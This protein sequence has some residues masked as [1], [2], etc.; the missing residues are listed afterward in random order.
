MFGFKK[1]K[2]RRWRSQPLP[3]AWIDIIERNF[4]YY[5]YLA[6]DERTKLQGHIQVFL[7]EKRF[8]GCEG[9][10][11]TDEIR[12]TIAA[13][14]CILLLHRR[15]N[16]FPLMKTILVYPHP[17]FVSATRR[18][19][20]GLVEEGIQSRLGESWHRGPIVLAWDDVL[21]SS[22]DPDD[23]HNVVFHEFAHELDSEYGTMDGT[24]PLPRNTMY[25]AWARVLSHEYRKLLDD[26]GTGHQ[27]LIRA[28][29]A[30]NPAEFFAVVTELFFERPIA[31]KTRHLE[32]YEQFRLFYEQ[33]PA[34]HHEKHRDR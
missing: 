24:P 31:L 20:G 17:Y 28:Y 21:K 6:P 13:Q 16:Y 22:L 19:A 32:L 15:S 30:T 26:L 4:P 5:Q 1:R 14:A 11:I 18:L 27:H 29:G 12:V 8:E 34:A 9:L 23:G 25:T 2:W 10:D 33:D 7:H 3:S